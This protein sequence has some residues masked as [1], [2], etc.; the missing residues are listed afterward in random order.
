MLL[1]ST[2]TLKIVILVYDNSYRKAHNR[3]NYII[4]LL[5]AI[6]EK[7]LNKKIVFI[8]RETKFKTSNAKILAD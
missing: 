6:L 1:H 7:K 5:K 4:E 8:I 3:L 2:T